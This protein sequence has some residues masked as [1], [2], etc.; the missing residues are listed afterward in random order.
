MPSCF[1][2]LKRFAVPL[3]F[4]LTPLVVFFSFV[5]FSYLS[6]FVLTGRRLERHVGNA[7]QPPRAKA[8]Y[9]S[10]SECGR[11]WGGGADALFRNRSG[12]AGLWF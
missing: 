11:C 6:F 5:G 1:K 9:A 4:F 3:F 10:E 12:T 2:S 7:A 8:E